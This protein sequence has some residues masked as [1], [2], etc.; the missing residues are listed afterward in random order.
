MPSVSACTFIAEPVE[1]FTFT[2]MPV[3]VSSVITFAM[4]FP[5]G[6]MVPPLSAVP[7]VRPRTSLSLLPEP[8]AAKTRHIAASRQRM[9]LLFFIP[10]SLFLNI[11]RALSLP[12]YHTI[13][14][15]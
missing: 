13:F 1:A 12:L 6:Y 2:L 7:M 9:L 5:T 15:A 14:A 4:A 11:R 10:Y 8:Q 3:V